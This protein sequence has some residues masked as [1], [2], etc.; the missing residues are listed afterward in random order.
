MTN[1]C[2]RSFLSYRRSQH[3]AA[4]LLIE[5]QHD[6]GIPTWQDVRDLENVRWNRS[7]TLSFSIRIQQMPC[8]S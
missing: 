1:P 7:F 4:K 5:A 3:A 6:L 2:G 8:G